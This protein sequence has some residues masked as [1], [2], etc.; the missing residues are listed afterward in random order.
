MTMFLAQIIK[1]VVYQIFFLD[2]LKFSTV[3]IK[4]IFY[5]KT[6]HCTWILLKSINMFL[7]ED[8]NKYE[9]KMFY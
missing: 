9:Q 3:F 4:L 8:K 2:F 6:V 1:Y 7:S 5:I